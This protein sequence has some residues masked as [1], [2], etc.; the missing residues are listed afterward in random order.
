MSRS[1]LA[2]FCLIAIYS[3]SNAQL[4][5]QVATQSGSFYPEKNNGIISLSSWNQIP[6]YDG[7]KYLMVQF[8]ELPKQDELKKLKNNS[9]ELLTY[10]PKNTY[11]VRV[12][13]NYQSNRF[14]D[15][16]IQSVFAPTSLQKIHSKIKQGEV[17]SYALKGNEY[18]LMVSLYNGIKAKDVQT[19]LQ[20]YQASIIDIYNDQHLTLSIHPSQIEILASLPFVQFIDFINAPFE[21]ENILNKTDHRSNV[22]NSD[23]SAGRHYDGAGVRVALTD[24]GFIGEHID[25]QGRT[26]QDAVL[27][28]NNGNH[29]DHCGGTIMG[30][31]NLDP[32]A[33]GMAPGCDLW[34]YEAI[35]SNNYI[36]NDTIYTSPTTSIDIVST[37]YSDGCNTGYNAGAE[38]ADRQIRTFENVMRIFSAGN[39]GTSNCS[40]GAGANWGNI[41]G[42]I[43]SS[44]NLIAVANLSSIDILNN[45]SSRGPATDG[46]I[47]PDVSAVGTDVYS[48]IDPNDYTLFTGTSMSCPGVAGVFTQMYQAYR[49]LNGGQDPNTGLLKGIMLNTC[50]DIGN[51]GPDFKHG[52]GRINALRAVKVI[53]NQNYSSGFVSTGGTNT[54]TLTIPPNTQRVKI[55]LNWLDREAAVSAS[56]ALV[57]DLDLVVT[58]PSS[59][60]FL[61]WVLN[62]TPN[63]VALNSNAI[64]AV[65]HL[66]NAEQVTIDN[67]VAGNYTLTVNGF[68]VPFGPQEY[69]ITYEIIENNAIEMAYPIGGEGFKPGE[70]QTLRWDAIPNGNTFSL[71]YSTDNGGS[72]NTITT[73]YSATQTYYNWTVP[74]T[75]SGNCKVRV[76]RNGYSAMSPS[77]FSI[78]N[79][80][81]N[82]NV[83][84]VCP[85]TITI[86]WSPSAGATSY[87]VSKLG[88]KYMDSIATT[89]DT[90]YHFVGLNILDS[91]WF[92]VKAKNAGLNAVGRRAFAV[93]QLPGL[94]NCILS[95]DASCVN[96]SSPGNMTLLDCVPPN[97]FPVNITLSNNGIA[98][99]SNL[100]MSYQLNSLT[101]I[102]EVYT[103]TINAGATA[104]YTFTAPLTGLVNGINTLKIWSNLAGDQYHLNDTL[105]YTIILK[106]SVVKSLPWIENFEANTICS[107]IPSCDYTNCVLLNNMENE[108]NNLMDQFDWKTNQG[109]TPTTATG[110]DID[111]T[112]G[113]ATGKYIYLESSYCFNQTA[114][115]LTPCFSFANGTKPYL[116]FWYHLYGV[117]QGDLHLDAFVDGLWQLDIIPVIS[118]NKG[119]VWQL[120]SKDLNAYLGK[121]VFFRFRGLTGNNSKSD[122]GIDDIQVVDSAAANSVFDIESTFNIYPNPSSQ[123][124]EITSNSALS[125]FDKIEI[126]NPLGAIITSQNNEQKS[127]RMSINISS[128]AEGVYWLVLKDKNKIVFRTK[129]IK[130]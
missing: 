113:N 22:L 88:T 15:V 3:K 70:T 64:R 57:N 129:M 92:S 11:L 36:L 121:T 126:Y 49:E 114:Q 78:I 54:T 13:N 120:Q 98:S 67:P 23:F 71:D 41:T 5:F 110:P 111:H 112:L 26:Y 104:N 127:S 45:S 93:Q 62:H 25:Y 46:R 47:K 33:K 20:Q 39:N 95:N 50:D 99:I 90:F 6:T 60:I 37:S 122:M 58:D 125:S 24:D 80:P 118:G 16:S 97:N 77:I 109:T 106:N 21:K 59:T 65:D 18:K 4:T 19:I 91:H 79:I 74:S 130:N 17:P 68:A 82:L 85:D 34:V 12:P 10:L 108:Q 61:P 73:G 52:Y 128:F 76:S 56:I 9:V 38:S 53:E 40:Y 87:E 81:A 72:W 105:S 66:N 55:M 2:L 14:D 44:K 101:P 84:R 119:N 42:G 8:S 103:G 86:T 43:K 89:T 107:G 35:S 48:T 117:D 102:N 7:H 124:V 69:F 94:L 100:P 30:A 75:L 28:V 116:S 96:S 83:T 51:P 27:S 123:T 115:L 32:N 63:A 31:G 1:L 29:G